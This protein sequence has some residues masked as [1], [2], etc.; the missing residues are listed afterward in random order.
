MNNKKREERKKKAEEWAKK[1]AQKQ[2]RKEAEKAA[3]QAEKINK[4][5][6]VLER[7]P[8]ECPKNALHQANLIQHKT[9]Q[10]EQT[11]EAIVI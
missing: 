11:S 5:P 9:V 1:A 2:A 8:Q 7:D 4:L 6:R 10:L 3:K